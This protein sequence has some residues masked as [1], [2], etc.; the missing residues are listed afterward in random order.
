M[1]HPSAIIHPAAEL[2]DTVSVGPF[3]IIEADVQIGAGT[4]IESPCGP[5]Q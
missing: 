1:I 3:S 5:N 4:V 2:A